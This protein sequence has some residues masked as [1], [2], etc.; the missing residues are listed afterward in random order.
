[1]EDDLPPEA[2]S[3]PIRATHEEYDMDQGTD[4]CRRGEDGHPELHESFAES[5][6][7][8]DDSTAEAAAR[9]PHSDATAEAG[10]GEVEAEQR[11]AFR[12]DGDWDDEADAPSS[13]YLDEVRRQQ[14]AIVLDTVAKRQDIV[15]KQQSKYS[16]P[17]YHVCMQM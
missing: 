6:A 11:S 15:A 9:W 14:V 3:A 16:F 13:L 17:C 4:N 7:G 5:P 8:L 1:M 10:V 12:Y 2:Q